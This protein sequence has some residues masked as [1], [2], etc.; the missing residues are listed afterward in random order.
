MQLLRHLD[1]VA[2]DPPPALGSPR[3]TDILER[4]M[5]TNTRSIA[6][7]TAPHPTPKPASSRRWKGWSAGAG[8]AAA[9]IVAGFVLVAPGGQS[10]AS[11]AVLSAANRTAGAHTLRLSAQYTSAEG[12][13]SGASA[14][15][16]GADST[17]TYSPGPNGVL[18]HTS[19][20]AEV[21]YLRDGRPVSERTQSLEDLLAPYA[22]SAADVVR[23]AL[24]HGGVTDLGD[25][26]VRGGTAKHYRVELSARSRA[27]L[28]AVRP[29]ELAWFEL[30]EPAQVDT[31]DVWVGSGDLLREIRVSGAHRTSTVQMYDFGA[32]ISITAPAGF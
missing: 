23:A 18:S 19:I 12:R 32:P 3:Y 17:I 27:A 13:K 14:A 5:S 4:A 6:A 22:R 1:P 7:P 30:E 8:L 15:I 10:S 26:S 24:N 29:Q 2:Q 11:A 28:T 31:V 9:A 20:G 25:T 16:E 21:Y